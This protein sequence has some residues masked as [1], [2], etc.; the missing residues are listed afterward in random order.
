MMRRFLAVGACAALAVT[1]SAGT[2]AAKPGDWSYRNKSTVDIR[3]DRCRDA[4]T[5]AIIGAYSGYRQPDDVFQTWFAADSRCTTRIRVRYM[6][7]GMTRAL[8]SNWKYKSGKVNSGV[9]YLDIWRCN[10]QIGA[11]RSDGTYY[12]VQ[13]HPTNL[14]NPR[15]K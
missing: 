14:E 9:S 3:T 6:K 10:S 2:A 1:S 13:T 4:K 11:K 7:K 5:T 8:Y 12:N 15:C